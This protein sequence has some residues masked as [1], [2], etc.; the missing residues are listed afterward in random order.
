MLSAVLLLIVALTMGATY[1]WTAP[2]FLAPIII[3]V[4]L[5]PFFFWWESRLSEDHALLPSTLWRLP[6]FT[7]LIVFGLIIYGWWAVG[8][9][10]LIEMFTV[11]RGDTI[12][13]AA[14]RT[15]PVGITAV[16]ISIVML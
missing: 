9:V 4:V 3:S 1:G 6:N 5:F 7:V 14:L 15:L 11:A 10:P 13:T 16:S 12:L 8:F 2:S